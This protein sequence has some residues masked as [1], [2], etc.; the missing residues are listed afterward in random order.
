MQSS[1]YSQLCKFVVRVC[2]YIKAT[3]Y[4]S[5]D[6][7]WC[8][9]ANS[10]PKSTHLYIIRFSSFFRFFFF[11][12]RQN[13]QKYWHWIIRGY[14]VELSR[15]DLY[16]FVCHIHSVISHILCFPKNPFW[17]F[18]MFWEF[19]N[20]NQA[21]L[22]RIYFFVKLFLLPSRRYSSWLSE[23][24]IFG[25]FGKF[26]PFLV[27][28]LRMV[29][30]TTFAGNSCHSTINFLQLQILNNLPSSFPKFYYLL[31]GVTGC[32]KFQ[33]YFVWIESMVV[34]TNKITLFTA[35]FPD[36]SKILISLWK[37]VK[38]IE[39]YPELRGSEFEFRQSMNFSFV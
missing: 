19:C 30:F 13:I 27:K 11:D 24:W 34:W 8:G 39:G 38:Q 36:E 3:R 25:E 29:N 26:Y 18:S 14:K 32:Q 22:S 31:T 4:N 2:M 6:I 5:T 28:I 20:T 37:V 21:L 33:A 23:K 15:S 1:R 7:I 17:T 35:E 10:N 16:L 9:L 12:K